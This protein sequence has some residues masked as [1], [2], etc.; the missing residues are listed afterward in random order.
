MKKNVI[1]IHIWLNN[2]HYIQ[3]SSRISPDYMAQQFDV[4]ERMRSI[5]IDWLIEVLKLLLPIEVY[6]G[7]REIFG[8]LIV[9]LIAI[10]KWIGTSQVRSKGR[11]VIPNC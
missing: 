2:D 1:L 10:R 3:V 5:L 7:D 8:Y 6:K 9:I 4:N 11:D